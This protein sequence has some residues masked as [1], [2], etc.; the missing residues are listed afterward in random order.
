MKHLKSSKHHLTLHSFLS[1]TG[2][3]VIIATGMAT[4]GEVEEVVNIYPDKSK[5]TLLHCVSN[6]PCSIES[7]NLKAMQTLQQAF[8]VKVGYS[9]HSVGS[10]A[11]TTSVALGGTVV[12][13]HFTLDKTLPGPDH[14]ASSDY[15]EF[16]ELVESIRSVEVALGTPTKL[17]QAEEAEM[18]AVSRKSIVLSRN[19]KKGEKIT[20]DHITLKRPGTGLYAREIENVLNKKASC[21][22]SKDH[23]LSWADFY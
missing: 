1:E 19:V 10:L 3:N 20:E 12:E 4:L 13:K 2:K 9:D 11:A 17:C 5:I 6:Y 15:L 14:R 21:D 22:L 7:L 16:S 18:A 23:I 8:N